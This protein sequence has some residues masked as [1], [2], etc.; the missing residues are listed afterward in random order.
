VGLRKHMFIGSILLLSAC[1]S[2]SP[3]SDST[4]NIT[5]SGGAGSVVPGTGTG[6]VVGASGNGGVAGAGSAGVGAGASGNGG[7][8]GGGISGLG[9]SGGTGGVGTAGAGA[10]GMGGVGG[11]TA[12]AG[13]SAGGGGTGGGAC[14]AS[15][16][17]LCH[18]PAPTALTS[19]AGPFKT[20]MYTISTGTVHYPTD[21]EPPFAAVAICGGLTNTGPEMAA[22][23]PFYASYGIVLVLTTTGAG[24]SAPM[25]GTELA[26]A[27]T[28]LKAENTKSGSPLFGKLSGRYGT[29]GYSLGGGGTTIASGM[30]AT[31]K[32]SIGLAPYNGMGTNVKVPTLLLCGASDT[33]A[34]CSM[35]MGVY[36][37]IPDSTP[38]MILAAIPG[39]THFSWFGPT[40]AAM[41]LSG[42]YALAFQKTFLEGDERW[43]TLLIAPPTGGMMTTNI[44]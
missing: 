23:G 43:K 39:A 13:G 21:A 25:R 18:G 19:S 9:G 16:D 8:G 22:W 36:T 41:G 29:S 24:D 32:T 38:K 17:C 34:P 27:I 35:A 37:G 1:S 30:D 14:C 11:A 31:L 4:G 33:T 28:A 12:G 26:A 6:G 42:Q 15:G 7:T 5:G 20:A 3:G 40:Q 44:K 10:S 2:N